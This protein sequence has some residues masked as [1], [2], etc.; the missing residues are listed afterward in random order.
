MKEK[1]FRAWDEELK[2]MSKPFFIT[3][4]FIEFDDDRIPFQLLQHKT[5]QRNRF[6]IMQHMGLTDNQGNELDWWEGDLFSI[7]GY[8]GKYELFYDNG[9]P[10][11]HESDT[12]YIM[13]FEEM[14]EDSELPNYITTKIGNKFEGEIE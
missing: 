10:S 1:K 11:F 7:E 8:R 6:I 12:G 5:L 14:V 2:R 4:V 3:D 9:V 13:S